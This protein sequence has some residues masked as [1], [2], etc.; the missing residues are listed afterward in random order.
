AQ[1][2]WRRHPSF[3]N[4]DATVGELAW[5]WGAGHRAAGAT[6]RHHLWTHESD[7]SAWGWIFAPMTTT[8]SA[9]TTRSEPTT[10]VWQ[11]HSD[12]AEL[13]DAVLEWFEAETPGVARQTSAREGDAQAI[14]RLQRHGYVRDEAAPWSLL[15]TRDLREIEE[16][17]LPK[18]YRL[19]TMR[20]I[21]DV[22]RRVEVHRAAWGHSSLTVASYTDVMSTCPYRDDLD[23]VLEAPDGSL[24]ASAIGWYDEENGVAEFEPVGTHPDHRRQGIGRALML[25]GL[26]RFHA[27]GATHAIVG[28]RGDA[29]YPIPKRL[30][31]S[32]G[33]RELSRELRFKRG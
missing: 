30:Y 12:H 24:V 26:Q 3:V 6:W 5:V 2:T 13:L 15:N 20:E 8:L 29:E 32:V 21:A 18:G 17:E 22:P 14:A 27:A 7:T 16:P 19:K 11:V 31:E 28:C 1:E 10:L 4:A 33:F 25:F 23:F 9:T